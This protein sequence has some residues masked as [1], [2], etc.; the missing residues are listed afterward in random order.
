MNKGRLV[1]D[2]KLAAPKTDPSGSKSRL[3]A[4]VSDSY[5]NNCSPYETI[6]TKMV[7]V[8]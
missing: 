2:G 6:Q 5:R 1:K 7:R 4:C 3:T 8:F